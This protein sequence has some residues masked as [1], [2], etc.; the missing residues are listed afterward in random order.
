MSFAEFEHFYPYVSHI[1]TCKKITFLI[2]WWQ[3]QGRGQNIL[4]FIVVNIQ[5]FS[6]WFQKCS[7]VYFICYKTVCPNQFIQITVCF[8]DLFFACFFVCFYEGHDATITLLCCFYFV[9]MFCFYVSM[10]LCFSPYKLTC[11]YVGFWKLFFCI[12]MTDLFIY[13]YIYIHACMYI[14]IYIYIY[15]RHFKQSKISLY[16]KQK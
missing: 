8:Y 15:I 11:F 5:T 1:L 12:Y 9:S 13:S 3:P 4:E 7:S 16:G 14:Y 6:I 10:F 2:P